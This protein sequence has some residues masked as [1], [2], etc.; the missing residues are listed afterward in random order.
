MCSRLCKQAPSV[1]AL[2]V[3]T[4]RISHKQSNTGNP[5]KNATLLTS[6]A[7]TPPSLFPTKPYII[8]N[9]TNSSTPT[10]RGLKEKCLQPLLAGPLVGLDFDCK[11]QFNPGCHV[12]PDYT[13]I[14]RA[15]VEREAEWAE[16]GAGFGDGEDGLLCHA[17]FCVC[18]LGHS[19]ESGEFLVI[20]L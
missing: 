11:A 2:V 5:A 14:V 16:F 10:T 17:K 8:R 18:S 4:S 15:T 12:I 1:S 3:R 6:H 13:T 19:W 7:Q 9:G 20:S